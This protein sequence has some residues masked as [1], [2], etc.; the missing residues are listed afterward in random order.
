MK[1]KNSN[2]ISLLFS[3]ITRGK[4]KPYIDMLNSKSIS[5]NMQMAAFGTAPSEMMD[6]FGLGSNDKDVVL[7][8]ATE[9]SVN[10]LLS[11]VGSD[12]TSNSKYGGLMMVLSLSAINRLTA[13]IVKKG[14]KDNTDE[15]VE[16]EMRNEHKHQLI[17]ISVNQGYTDEVMQTARKAGA[18]GGT[19]IR[20][21]Q[22]GVE[23]FEEFGVT[24]VSDENE[25]ITI[26]APISKA[27]E[28]MN[29]VNSAHG[30][31]TECKGTVF[32]LPVDK[33]L[34]I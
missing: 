30:M 6:V 31:N 1:A 18:T 23:L 33:A 5:F 2:R 34:K 24:G 19:I 26:L 25:I 7:S 27:E 15:G 8:L 16:N 4:S 3:I 11:V 17:I 28:I 22:V 20:A 29:D 32:A 14:V 10:S 21:R 9:K 13:E 12:L